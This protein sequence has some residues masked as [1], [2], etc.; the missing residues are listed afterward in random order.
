MQVTAKAT[1]SGKWWAIQVPEVPGVFSQ[2][3]RLDQVPEMAADAVATMLGIP[4]QSVEVKVEAE[5]P[6]ESNEAVQESR[7]RAAEAIRV[8]AESQAL[9]RVV[10]ADLKRQGLTVR[11]ISIVMGVSPQRV[12][13]LVPNRHR[14][15]KSHRSEK[16]QKVDA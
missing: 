11:E 2:A 8:Q 5:L 14:S 1:R 9:S 3:K 10:I 12:S 15:V 4:A 6:A 13:Q 7:E 16:R